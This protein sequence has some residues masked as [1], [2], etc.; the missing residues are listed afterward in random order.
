M[1][2]FGEL[3]DLL[4]E[5]SGR[6]SGSRVLNPVMCKYGYILNILSDVAQ[7]YQ[8]ARCDLSTCALKPHCNYLGNVPTM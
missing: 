4:G 2:N 1:R 5:V 8:L 7:H 6:S 3:S